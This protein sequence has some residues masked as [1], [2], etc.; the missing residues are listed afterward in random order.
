M[1]LVHAGFKV[2]LAH[3]AD[4]FQDRTASS[5]Y[6]L[7]VICHS[8]PEAEKQVILE[9]VSPSSSSVLAVPTLQP[10]NTFLSQVQQLLA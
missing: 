3:S 10:P 1:I 5:S 9:A 8:V 2:E 4:E 7:L 6:A